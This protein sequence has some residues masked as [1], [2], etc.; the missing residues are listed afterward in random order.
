MS[1]KRTA[2]ER[3]LAIVNNS[4]L[5]VVAFVTLFPFYYILIYSLSLPDRALTGVYFLPKGFTLTNYVAVFERNNILHAIFIS[6][7]RSVVGTLAAV[8]GCSMLAYGI[9]KKALPFRKTMYRLLI[10]AMYFN[11]GLI[12]WYL[13]MRKLGLYNNFLLYIFPTVIVTFFVIL[14]KTFF[15][16]LP[17][18]LE[19]SAMV[20]G[21]GHFTV[22]RM[23]VL[24]LSKPILATIALYQAVIQWNSWVDN[25]YLAP[26]ENLKTLQLLLYSFLTELSSAQS[27]LLH[28]TSTQVIQVTPESIRMTITVV[29]ILPVLCIYPF[30]QKYFQTGI[31]IGAVKG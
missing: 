23:I 4:L 1:M 12:P 8:A 3:I 19:E 7:S 16:Q 22:F 2:S 24:P 18:S 13:T 15:E 11:V 31:L 27:A 28:N 29:A 20:D 10:I 30:M 25:F 26:S 9:S 6:V 5:L 14:L 17:A 21:A